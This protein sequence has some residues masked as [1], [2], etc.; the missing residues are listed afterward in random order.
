MQTV[1][2][3]MA[4]IVIIMVTGRDEPVDKV[5]GLEV[6]ADDY[7]T[8]PFDDRELLARVRSLL[9]RLQARVDEAPPST[10]RVT[11]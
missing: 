9:R 2:R 1:E 11:N 10:G 4:G 3:K 5:V 7:V 6:G 8:K